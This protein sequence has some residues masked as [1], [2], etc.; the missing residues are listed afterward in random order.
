MNNYFPLLIIILVVVLLA[1]GAYFLYEYV[2]YSVDQAYRELP[3]KVRVGSGKNMKNCPKGCTRGTCKYNPKCR[4]HLGSD[5]E[6]CA[7]DFQ[8]QYCRDK[9]GEYYLKPWENPWIDSEYNNPDAPTDELNQVIQEQNDYI[10]QLNKQIRHKN[11]MIS[12]REPPM[13]LK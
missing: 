10:K 4:N 5:P 13:S 7:F 12:R 9:T 3:T 11:D 1:I 6:C 2:E 8:C